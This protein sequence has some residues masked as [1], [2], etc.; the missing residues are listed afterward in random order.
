MPGAARKKRGKP[1]RSDVRS[2]KK[3]GTKLL[4]FLPAFAF[5]MHCT[6]FL[7]GRIYPLT[8]LLPAFV[9]ISAMELSPTFYI[10]RA[11]IL[12]SRQQFH[13]QKS[14]PDA[15]QLTPIPLERKFSL[16]IPCPPL[17]LLPMLS[18]LQGDPSGQLKPPVDLVLT[19]LAACRL[20][21]AK[22]G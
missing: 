5:F 3:N 6:F 12:R 16:S 11:F 7:R 14:T 8:P 19:V 13:N 15:T 1:S 17:L 21:T 10:C 20:P 18:P 4:P 22:S 2:L 9:A